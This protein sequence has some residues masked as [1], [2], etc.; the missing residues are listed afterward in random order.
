MSPQAKVIFG[1]RFG[2]Y[3]KYDIASMVFDPVSGQLFLCGNGTNTLL[4]LLPETQEVSDTGI[5]TDKTQFCVFDPDR[6][7]ISFAN[8]AAEKLVLVDVEGRKIVSDRALGTLPP[9][10]IIMGY[11]SSENVLI[12][13]SEA[14]V[15]PAAS[16][17]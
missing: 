17:S 6:R 13:A 2:I 14:A 4:A 8:R 15:S 11:N 5:I 10:E 1:P 9:G 12:A 16:R 3:T 7:Q